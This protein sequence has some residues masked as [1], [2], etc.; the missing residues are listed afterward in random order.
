[1]KTKA[2]CSSETSVD[3]Q[4]T[5]V[6]ISKRRSREIISVNLLCPIPIREFLSFKYRVIEDPYFQDLCFGSFCTTLVFC[7]FVVYI[8]LIL[9]TVRFILYCMKYSSYRG[10]FQAKVVDCGDNFMLRADFEYD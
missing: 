3:F 10:L 4:R 2:A 8:A 1:M 7:S 6:R 9:H 5:D